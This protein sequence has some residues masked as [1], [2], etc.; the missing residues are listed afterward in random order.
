MSNDNYSPSVQVSLAR[1][2]NKLFDE[3][4]IRLA[5][6]ENWKASLKADNQNEYWFEL[7]LS[8]DN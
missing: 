2:L 8:S 4:F 6:G 1:S 7:D 5:T 3:L